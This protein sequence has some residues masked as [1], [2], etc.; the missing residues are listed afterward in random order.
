MRAY[1]PRFGELRS[2]QEY[3]AVGEALTEASEYDSWVHYEIQQALLPL[4]VLALP[5]RHADNLDR[6]DTSIRAA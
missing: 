4:V 6:P 3:M 2:H 5:T 1:S